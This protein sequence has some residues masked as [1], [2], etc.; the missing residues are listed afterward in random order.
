MLGRRQFVQAGALTA[1]GVA[2]GACSDSTGDV[3]ASPT[4]NRDT[5]AS[6]PVVSSPKPLRTLVT[7][8][9]ADPWARGS[10]S[11]L[12]VG[13]PFTVR[14]RLAE[15]FGAQRIALAGEY[16][17]TDHPATAHGAYGSGLRAAD[18]L[19]RAHPAAASAVVVGAGMAGVAAARRLTDGG[20]RVTVLEARDRIGGRVFTDTRSGV[21]LE[22]GASWVHGV[23]GNPLAPLAKR[24]GLTLVPTDFDDAAIRSYRTSAFPAEG[25]RPVKNLWRAVHRAT[26]TRPPVD[27]SVERQLASFGWSVTTPGERAAAMTELVQEYGLDLDRLGAQ[28]LWEGD[29][30]RGGDAMVVGGYGA[31]PRMLADGIDVRLQSPVRS[32]STQADSVTARLGDGSTDADVVV[33]AV[34]LALLQEGLPEVPL[35]ASMRRAVDGLTTGNLEK[36]FVEYA[37]PWWPHR[38][39]LQVTESPNDRWTEW[40]DLRALTGR[41]VVFGFSGGSAARR[42]P[43]SDEAC[44]AE[45]VDALQTA[46]A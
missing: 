10:Y 9:D 26:R 33:V 11:A 28:A 12:S 42:R 34:P 8:W 25:W 15:L 36:V 18:R 27:A 19:L 43:K 17:A 7:R 22:Q 24:A 31:I 20:V 35:P 3:V 39:L 21:A 44:A 6:G 32:I 45:A 30:E 23:T 2:L 37:T 4:N 5:R 1:F 41:P 13:T 16:C 14:F 38:Q 40:Y 29:Y 46:Y